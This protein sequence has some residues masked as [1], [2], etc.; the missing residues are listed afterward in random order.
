MFAIRWLF[1]IILLP[2]LLY[3][4]ITYMD[5]EEESDPHRHGQPLFAEEKAYQLEERNV[6]PTATPN[7]KQY[8]YTKTKS[9]W[10]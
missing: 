9:F 5:L 4:E 7:V 2:L 10:L 6:S 3:L 8:I 1:I